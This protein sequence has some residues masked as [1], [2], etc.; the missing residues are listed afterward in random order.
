MSQEH[1]FAVGF[2]LKGITVTSHWYVGEY[3]GRY[4]F[5]NRR[6]GKRVRL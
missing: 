5:E 2:A 4:V 3:C 6:T 1:A